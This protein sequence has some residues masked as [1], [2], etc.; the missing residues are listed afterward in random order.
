MSGVEMSRNIV[1]NEA[2]LDV[3]VWWLGLNFDIDRTAVVIR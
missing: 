1:S 2:T 3:F